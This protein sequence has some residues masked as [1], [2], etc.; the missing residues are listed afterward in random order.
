MGD[1][2][3]GGD[4]SGQVQETFLASEQED[5]E[6]EITDNVGSHPTSEF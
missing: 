4:N 1:L 6:P 2:K 5:I 3:Q